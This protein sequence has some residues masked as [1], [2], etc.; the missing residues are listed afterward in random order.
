[1]L[2]K[3]FVPDTDPTPLEDLE[4]DVARATK[5]GL[6]RVGASLLLHVTIDGGGWSEELNLIG[7]P[8]VIFGL[9]GVLDAHSLAECED[10]PC[11]VCREAWD[12]PITR[13]EAIFNKNASPLEL[14]GI[15]V[16]GD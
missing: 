13:L 2:H 15:R 4:R 10:Q 6:H 3:V 16:L 1:M 12:T 8:D 5:V 14:E 11:I 9:L 7:I